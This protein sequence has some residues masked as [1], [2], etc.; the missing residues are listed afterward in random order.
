MKTKLIAAAVIAAVSFSANSA[1]PESFSFGVGG[2][3]N[4]QYGSLTN[5]RVNGDIFSN[6]IT[7]KNGYG[8]KVDA[9]YNFTDWF[10]LGLGYNYLNGAKVGTEDQ[11]GYSNTAKIHTNIAELYGRFAYPLD[12]VG[13]DIF[14]KVG[15][16]YNRTSCLGSN[17]SK[18]SFVAGLGGQWALTKNIALR[19]GYDYFYNTYNKDGDKL[20]NGLLYATVQFTFGG[21]ADPAPQK[22]VVKVTQKFNLDQKILFPFDSAKLSQNGLD[23]VAQLEASSADIK[24]ADFSVY[25]YTDRIGSDEYNLV[26]SQKRADAVT[27]KLKDDGVTSVTTSEGRGKADPVTGDKCDTVK[28][29]KAL[30]DCLA[31]DRRVEVIVTG[32]VEVDE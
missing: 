19:A 15:P 18:G 12:N 28:G 2:G 25:G 20:K 14:F 11:Y 16:T 24:G 10:A 32:E 5:D 8:I 6:K 30:V 17:S 7:S 1:L 9:E 23:A 29:K 27:N 22:Q 13:S 21:P 3:W 4:H 26:L 31:P